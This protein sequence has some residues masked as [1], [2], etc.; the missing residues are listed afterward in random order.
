MKNT[1]PFV[2][3]NND[4]LATTRLNSTQK[5]FISYILGWQKNNLTCKMTNNN[6]ATHFGMKYAG[7]RSMLNKLNTYKFFETTQ[8]GNT[9]ENSTWTS[10]HEIKVD[11]AK[12]IEFLNAGKT[13]KKILEEKEDYIEIS[14]SETEKNFDIDEVEQQQNVE[15]VNVIRECVK[16]L[17]PI[18]LL[19]TEKGYMSLSE[20]DTSSKFLKLLEENTHFDN[21]CIVE[22]ENNTSTI[23][24]S[25]QALE[26]L[27]D[28]QFKESEQLK[29]EE[30][31]EEEEIVTADLVE[32]E[33]VTQYND[34]DMINVKNIMKDIGFTGDEIDLAINH[35][36]TDN[37]TFYKFSYYIVG[38][39]FAQKNEDYSGILISQ[40]QLTMIGKM[41]I[42]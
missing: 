31:E 41:S 23:L 2:M 24:K 25:L 27:L 35:F 40:D 42:Y 14:K 21:E 37:V 16:S 3:V 26:S 5:L 39:S 20:Q 11:E 15:R 28:L 29:E 19:M 6:L 10:G 30:E 36:K 17:R 22:M 12:L 13:D 38:L 7:I 9:N 32:L 34:S 8:Y 4:L 1:Q 18:E 33:P